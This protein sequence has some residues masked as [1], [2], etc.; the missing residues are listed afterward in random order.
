[1]YNFII[2]MLNKITTSTYIRWVLLLVIA[3]TDIYVVKNPT[4]QVLIFFLPP[5]F[6][7]LHSFNY[8]GK[9]NTLVMF[10]IIIVVSFAAEYLGVHTGKIFGLYYY[11]PSPKVNGFLISGVPPLIT[12]SYISIAYTSYVLA[13]V[14]LGKLGRLSGI[15]LASVAIV[16][17]M[18]TTLWDMTFDPIASYVHNIYTW[19]AGGAYFGVPFRNFT[20]WFLESLV[21]FLIINVYLFSFSKNKDYSP[22]PS[23]LFLGEAVFLVAAN[24]F[25][26]IYHEFFRPTEVQQAMALIPIFALG[27]PIVIATFKLLDKSK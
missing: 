7:L 22:K 8:F 19:Y 2:L 13:R 11:N 10:L 4:L 3:V 26:T 5:I 17:A 15:S 14:V 24:A 20:G 21:F 16:G 18:V 23:S 27:T 6:A 12:L 9:K 1:M 25:S